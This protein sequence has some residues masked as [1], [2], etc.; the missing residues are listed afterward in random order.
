MAVDL[1]GGRLVLRLKLRLDV[2]GR[3]AVL[4]RACNHEMEVVR[5]LYYVTGVSEAVR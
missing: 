5:S 3:L 2:R 1:L 4:L